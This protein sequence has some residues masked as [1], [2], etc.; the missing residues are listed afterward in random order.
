M[1]SRFDELVTITASASS[2]DAPFDHDNSCTVCLHAYIMQRQLVG[3]TL[4]ERVSFV[5]QE[6]EGDGSVINGNRQVCRDDDRFTGRLVDPAALVLDLR[7][8][9]LREYRRRHTN[10]ERATADQSALRD[11]SRGLDIV[12]RSARRLQ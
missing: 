11:G 1:T 6:V 3:P 4:L 9:L 12:Q 8:Y 10:D 5:F 7:H 2:T